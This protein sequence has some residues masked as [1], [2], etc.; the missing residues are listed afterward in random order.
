MNRFIWVDKITEPAEEILEIHKISFERYKGEIIYGIEVCYKNKPWEKI[1]L[2]E[3]EFYNL[4]FE[5][6]ISIEELRE[7]RLE[8]LS[9]DFKEDF[10]SGYFYGCED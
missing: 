5:Y 10:G 6:D 7:L 9:K 2:D 1:E 3:V 4:P 8:E